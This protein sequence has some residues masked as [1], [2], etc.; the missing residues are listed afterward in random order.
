[1][2]ERFLEAGGGCGF[3]V[4]FCRNIVEEEVHHDLLESFLILEG[5]CE[6]HITNEKE[7]PK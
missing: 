1:M 7:I 2:D 4:R 6:C 5:S 3:F